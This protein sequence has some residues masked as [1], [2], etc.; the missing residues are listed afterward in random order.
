VS[1]RDGHAPPSGG[2]G[3]GTREVPGPGS[4]GPAGGGT[5]TVKYAGSDS[6][7][8][9]PPDSIQA[10]GE[11]VQRAVRSAPVEVALQP[12]DARKE[13]WR[14]RRAPRAP[15]GRGASARPGVSSGSPRPTR[16]RRAS[17]RAEFLA[18]A[19]HVD[20]E[21]ALGALALGS[22]TLSTSQLRWIARPG[23]AR[24]PRG[25]RTRP[26][27]GRRS[28]PLTA[29]V[30][31]SRSR[32]RSP[33]TIAPPCSITG[34]R[35]RA[36]TR[37][38]SS[39]G[40]KGLVT[41][42]RRRAAARG[43][44]RACRCAPR[45]S[46]PARN[47]VRAHL[48]QDVEAVG[49][50]QHQVEDDERVG[51]GRFAHRRVAVREP[52]RSKPAPSRWRRSAARARG[53]LRLRGC[54]VSWPPG[55]QTMLRGAEGRRRQ[56]RVPSCRGDPW[57]PLQ[58]QHAGRRRGAEAPPRN[59]GGPGLPGRRQSRAAGRANPWPALRPP[60]RGGDRRRGPAGKIA[61]YLAIQT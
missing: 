40:Q 39:S 42:R 58:R 1:R 38:R 57:V 20:V 59:R 34:R 5:T 28:H 10:T 7:R 27:S 16:W 55:I 12:H 48:F 18:Q 8:S 47:S 26:S 29:T 50:R 37:A 44:C 31:A 45:G 52:R 4:A 51:L 41:N 2:I 32:T 54:A 6:Q 61:R 19:R 23:A 49:A 43:P 60:G 24:A 36:R 46:A 3:G 9:R 13:R 15:G 11:I 14:R 22:S 33:A 25:D 53:R 21:R 35:S 17:P 56:V 30:R